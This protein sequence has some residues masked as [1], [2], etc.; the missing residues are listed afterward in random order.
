MIR[1]SFPAEETR[2]LGGVTQG[3]LCPHEREL[4]CTKWPSAPT[5]GG[6]LCHLQDKALLWF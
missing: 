5:I 3:M 2:C 6:W 4:G 1:G